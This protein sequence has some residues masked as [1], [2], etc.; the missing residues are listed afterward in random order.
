LSNAIA[1]SVE[2]FVRVADGVNEVY[3]ALQRE[4]EAAAERRVSRGHRVADRVKSGRDRGPADDQPAE[5]VVQAAHRE[6]RCDG[7]EYVEPSGVHRDRAQYRGK[8]VRV[9]NAA[10]ALVFRKRRDQEDHRAV[11]TAPDADGA[12][13]EPGNDPRGARSW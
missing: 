5:R 3:G 2:I 6:D 8:H 13:V 7:F 11:V 1:S 9:A 10:E 12:L 4:A